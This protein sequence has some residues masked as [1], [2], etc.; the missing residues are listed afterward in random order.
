MKVNTYLYVHCVG[1]ISY[2]YLTVWPLYFLVFLCFAL[3]FLFIVYFAM[4][5]MSATYVVVRCLVS[6]TLVCCV[7]M[8]EDMTIVAMDCK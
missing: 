1:F 4:P 3:F 6:V 2:Y 7:E 8:A 5:C